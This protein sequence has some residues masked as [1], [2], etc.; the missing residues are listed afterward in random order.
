MVLK[1]INTMTSNFDMLTFHVW[2]VSNRT[3]PKTGFMFIVKNT[4]RRGDV[5]Y[6]VM[7]H[8]RSTL[9]ETVT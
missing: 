4:K 2:N 9:L 5:C 7:E 6:D 3:K 1:L 8:Y